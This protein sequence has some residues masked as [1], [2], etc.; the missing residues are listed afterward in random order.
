[1][2][3]PNNISSQS[4]IPDEQ[5][6]AYLEGKLS[7]D[8]QR[9]VEAL[10]SD[11]GMESDAIDGLKRINAHEAKQLANKINYKL[12][13]DLRKAKRVKRNHFVD[14]KWGWVAVLVVLML[15]VLAFIVL[16]T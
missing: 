13:N 10:L 16:K 5:L 2:T 8:E 1:M 12:Q 7:A 15:V 9:V 11:E 6:I 14:N 3:R 4:N